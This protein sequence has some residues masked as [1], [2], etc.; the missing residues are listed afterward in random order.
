VESVRHL[1]ALDAQRLP[2]HVAIIMDGNGRWAK[3]RGLS[4]VEGHR[5]A[6]QSVREVV[7]AA[8]EVGVSY[9]TLYA[10]SSENWQR[11][12]LE[13]QTLMALL[14]QV[15]AAEEKRLI[16]NGIRLQ[17]IG[18]PNRLPAPLTQRLHQA[19]QRTASGNRLTLTLALSYGGRQEIVAAVQAIS[20]AAQE[21]RLSPENIDETTVKSYLW[22]QALPE[23]ELLI[24]TSGEARISNFLL[25][26][27][28]YTE[29][30]FT[31]VLWPDFRR[32]HF[33]EAL[34]AY[35]QRERRF[36]RVSA[37]S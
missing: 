7:E 33:Y 30:Y 14:S 32:E 1:Q 12:A 10:F 13:V 4:R 26:D 16:D 22:T 5:S 23:P 19:V 18:E 21:G 35:Q 8:A 37:S 28:A 11:P 25:W 20:R 27:I 17:V 2:C 36:G 9:L 31:P 34:W 29:F 15:L 6:I 24:R 3:A